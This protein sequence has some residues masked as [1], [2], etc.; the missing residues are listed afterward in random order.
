MRRIA[1]VSATL[2]V[3]A[4]VASF[5]GPATR[6]VPDAKDCRSND[7]VTLVTNAASFSYT[8]SAK[9][10]DPSSEPDRF[11]VCATQGGVTVFYFGGDMQSDAE[12]NDGALGT[13]GVIIAADQN[14]AQGQD[15]EDWSN[16]GND[17][18]WDTADDRDC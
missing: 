8:D 10:L 1:I 17:D 3:L 4:P 16:P 13:C 6:D 5:A 14:L 7:Q 9:E 15:G 2:A 18:R 11:A 12:D